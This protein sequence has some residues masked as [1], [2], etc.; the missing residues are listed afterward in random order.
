MASNATTERLIEKLE[1]L[2]R[3]YNEVSDE[4]NSPEVAGN[5][6]RIVQ[7]NKEH[8]KLRRIV[9]PYL[10]YRKALADVEENQSLLEDASVDAELKALAKEEIA[11]GRRR[12]E[13]LLES[14]KKTLVTGE[15][16]AVGSVILEIR[17]GTGGEEAALFAGDL[18]S[19]YQRFAERHG[20]K[21]EV[22]DASPSDLGGYREVVLN[23]KGEGVYQHF[24]YEG[25]GHRVQRVPQTEA[26]GRIHTSAATVAVLPEPEE[27][28]VQ[29]DWEKDVIEHVSR[30]GGP[31]GQNVNKVSS[32][33]KLEHI[34][35][36]ITVSMRDEKSQHKN[37]AKARRILMSRVYDHILTSQIAQ[38]DASRRT[39][40]GSGD[41]SQRIRTYNFPQNRCT[42]HR[43]GMDANLDRVMQ[44]DLDD[45]VFALQA[46]DV[47]QRIQNL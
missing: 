15:D 3:R 35:T 23:I 19:M 47:E 16:A 27:V 37:R 18:F 45:I 25:G 17:A 42:D 5:A 41:R 38:R 46:R 22:L 21:V 20:F 7:L 10:A 34:P 29:I 43:I 8:G 31:G 9:E 39:M 13:E 30:A 12:C 6:A 24:G 33:I 4:M 2:R 11:A 36:G 40:I 1:D 26:Q 32:A 44:G 28:D 14:L